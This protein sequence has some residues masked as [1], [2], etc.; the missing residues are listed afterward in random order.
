MIQYRTLSLIG[1]E[2]TEDDI[3]KAG[4]IPVVDMGKYDFGF[5]PKLT[6]TTK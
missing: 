6:I 2:H 4:D 1:E 5:F 3:L